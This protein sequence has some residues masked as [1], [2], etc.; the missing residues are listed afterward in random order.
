[1]ID[2]NWL[3]RNIN[4]LIASIGPP[5][6]QSQMPNGNMMYQFQYPNVL[7]GFNGPLTFKCDVTFVSDKTT[8]RIIGHSSNGMTCVAAEDDNTATN[9]K[10]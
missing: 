2:R 7:P 10:K 4:D 1:M 9:P 5:Q 8:S 6:G 3:G